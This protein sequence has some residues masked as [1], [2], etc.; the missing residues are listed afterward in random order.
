MEVVMATSSI[1]MVIGQRGLNMIIC[2]ATQII[3]KVLSLIIFQEG[4][5]IFMFVPLIIVPS[6]AL[7]SW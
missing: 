2:P 7:L 6:L 5:T 1:D 4:G 3:M